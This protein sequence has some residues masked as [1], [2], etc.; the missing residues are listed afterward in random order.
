MGEFWSHLH[1]MSP[2][3]SLATTIA[4]KH[5]LSTYWMKGCQEQITTAVTSP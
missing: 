4:N 3:P 5:V 2:L 1:P